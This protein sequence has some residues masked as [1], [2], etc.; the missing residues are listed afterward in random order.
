MEAELARLRKLVGD[1]D[2]TGSNY[3][4]VNTNAGV[5][6]H[7][8]NTNPGTRDHTVNYN[9][10]HTASYSGVETRSGYPSNFGMPGYEPRAGFS[11]TNGIDN[12][13]GYRRSFS[14][15]IQ[16]RPLPSQQPPA[17]YVPHWGLQ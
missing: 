14:Q 17:R 10:G 4:G 1:Q 15:S 2:P 7:G 16:S 12:R 9:G 13:Q 11:G 3:S 6:Y 8:M 5:N